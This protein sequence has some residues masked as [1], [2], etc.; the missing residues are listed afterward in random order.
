MYKSLDVDGKQN[1]TSNTAGIIGERFQ[2]ISSQT[3]TWTK[4]L[5]YRKIRAFI[6][7]KKGATTDN[8]VI[9]K[10]VCVIGRNP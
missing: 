9:N 3:H 2:S 6:Q 7:K 1:H 10:Q 4:Q 8:E 5:L